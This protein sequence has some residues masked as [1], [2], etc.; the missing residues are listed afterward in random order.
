MSRKTRILLVVLTILAIAVIGAVMWRN[1]AFVWD[2]A[3]MWRN[4]SGVI[5]AAVMPGTGAA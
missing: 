2:W 5:Y 3:V 4:M 1:A